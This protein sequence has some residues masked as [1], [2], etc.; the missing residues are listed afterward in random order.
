MAAAVVDPQVDVDDAV[1]RIKA[2]AGEVRALVERWRSWAAA[3]RSLAAID[4]RLGKDFDA[5]LKLTRATA[6]DAAAALLLSQAPA[7]AAAEMLGTANGLSVRTPPLIG[8]DRAAVEYTA[9][10]TWQD[11]AWS[12]DPSLPEVQPYW[13]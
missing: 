5:A 13:P 1:E 7:D 9:A 10:R 11:C 2:Q 4:R 8:Y 6:R 3:S 12:I